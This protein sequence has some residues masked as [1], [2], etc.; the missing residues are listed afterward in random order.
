MQLCSTVFCRAQS[1]L[2]HVV[3]PVRVVQAANAARA[4]AGQQHLRPCV[5]PQLAQQPR[6]HRARDALAA[7]QPAARPV[8]ACMRSLSVV[9]YGKGSGG[10]PDLTRRIV[11]RSEC[12]APYPGFAAAGRQRGSHSAQHHAS[13]GTRLDDSQVLVV[14]SQG[15][16]LP[17]RCPLLRG[18]TLSARFG[19]LTCNTAALA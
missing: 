15:P 18:K 5:Q 19:C 7:E 9:L 2:Q 6:R 17:E 11:S 13:P 16:P 14:Q 1:A 10:S 3:Q 8:C 12:A 4:V